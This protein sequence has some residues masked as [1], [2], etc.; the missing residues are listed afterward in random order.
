VED[1]PPPSLTGRPGAV[2]KTLLPPGTLSC[3]LRPLSSFVCAASY[4]HQ[5]V[6]PLSDCPARSPSRLAWRNAAGQ[7]FRRE[8]L[9]ASARCDGVRTRAAAVPQQLGRRSLDTGRRCTVL[10]AALAPPGRRPC[11]C[12]AAMSGAPAPWL[13]CVVVGSKTDPGRRHPPS[14]TCR[15]EPGAEWCGDA[16]QAGVLSALAWKA[17]LRMRLCS[18]FAR[19]AQR[20]S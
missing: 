14:A 4:H 2:A 11:R 17:S 16:G 15:E 10:V 5:L 19:H 1:E 9:H 13:A 20:H 8:R 18:T 6:Y 12:S 3:L 7:R